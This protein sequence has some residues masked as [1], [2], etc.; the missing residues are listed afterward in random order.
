ML[1]VAQA[2]PRHEQTLRRAMRSWSGTWVEA[3]GLQ[4]AGLRQQ[5]VNSIYWAFTTVATVGYGDI[6]PKN[7]KE[8]VLAILVMCR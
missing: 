7:L 1:A 3:Q 6:T 4:D 2:E 8:K 5:Y